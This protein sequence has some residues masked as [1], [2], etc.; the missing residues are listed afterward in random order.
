MSDAQI[1]SAVRSGSVG[2]VC[3]M[4]VWAGWAVGGTVAD[5]AAER[6]RGIK[7]LLES[8]AET[9][10]APGYAVGIVVDDK[11]VLAN[12]FGK[13]DLASGEPVD[14]DTLFAIGST[15]KAMTAAVIAKLIDQRKM[16]WDDPARRFVPELEFRDETTD[17]NATIRDLL[18]HRTGLG[19]MDLLWYAGTATYQDLVRAIAEAEPRAAFR[20]EFHYQNLMYLMAGMASVHAAGA[21]DWDT[22]VHEML[23]EPLGMHRSNT[24][25]RAMTAD[26]NHATGY[27]W[28][29]R[30]SAFEVLP[31]RDLSLI[32]PAGAV[33]ASVNDM[34]QWVRLQLGRGEVDD[35]RLISTKRVEEM[36]TPVVRMGPGA[37]YALGWMVRTWND[38]RMITHTGGIDGF[39]ARV[40]LLPD[41]GIG[42]VVLAN[43]MDSPLLGLADDI[44]L[45]GLL[46]DPGDADVDM[47]DRLQWEDFKGRYW[48][49]T[50]GVECTVRE[51]DGRLAIDVPGQ[52]AFEL[53]TPDDEGR[54]RFRGFEDIAVRFD[55]DDAGQVVQVTLFQSGLQYEL[56]RVDAIR[57][58]EVDERDVA[59]ALGRYRHEQSGLTI[60]LLI[61]NGRLAVDIP[62]E[63][64]YELRKPDDEGRW[65]FRMTDRFWIRL[66]DAS[67]RAES[68]EL[69]GAPGPATFERVDEPEGDPLPSV[70]TLMENVH[71]A[72]GAEPYGEIFNLTLEYEVDFVHM[73]VRGR[74]RVIMAGFDRLQVHLDLP[75]FGW[76]RLA[77]IGRMGWT[78]SSWEPHRQLAGKELRQAHLQHPLV[79]LVEWDWHMDAIE[80][81]GR[82]RI[83]GD[84]RAIEVRFMPA[85]LPPRTIRFHEQTGLPLTME[86]STVLENGSTVRTEAQY[87]SW[88]RVEG[89]AVPETMTVRG[90][91]TGEFRFELV[92]FR[93]NEEFAEDPFTL[94]EPMGPD[95]RPSP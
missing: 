41:D 88:R 92:D 89:V 23:L 28:D 71:A 31:M 3:A 19:G 95:G 90:E 82:E 50:L 10:R 83:D 18:S 55:R 22:L 91:Q 75:P 66:P 54:R 67:A 46:E 52:M 32:A 44:I 63:M 80:V 21:A 1:R 25:V 5:D 68:V 17:G 30:S 78:Q 51:I 27:R 26:A 20:R 36:W 15:T 35:R 69:M 70:R 93:F 9:F 81:R 47:A 2:L 53:R 77:A 87:L 16:D 65:I 62:G 40:T 8:R 4:S 60:R 39:G 73:G 56:P 59:W 85:G 38:R 79:W 43:T 6:V 58:P 72:A 13:R 94:F 29:Q 49:E 45:G 57:A 42:Y 76:S 33:N 34:M 14:A 64:I 86:Y 84:Q 24:S 11:V 12:G 48:F 61:R 74:Q 37:E 7:A